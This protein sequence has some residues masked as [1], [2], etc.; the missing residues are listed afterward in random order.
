MWRKPVVC[1][2]VRTSGWIYP[3][4]AICTRPEGCGQRTR[5]IAARN[6]LGKGSAS[7][8]VQTEAIGYSGQ[9]KNFTTAGVRGQ[10]TR[11]DPPGNET[12]S[13][14]TRSTAAGFDH[15]RSNLRDLKGNGGRS[16]GRTSGPIFLW[17]IRVCRGAD[18]SSAA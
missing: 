11:K 15:S 1:V 7:A 17:I 5:C 2:E 14:V 6:T 8:D 10:R 9:E 12:A 13:A 18:G 16:R 3:V 4:E